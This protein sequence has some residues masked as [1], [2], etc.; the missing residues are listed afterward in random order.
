MHDDDVPVGRLFTRR[1]VLTL[2][3][4]TAGSLAAGMPFDPLARSQAEGLPRCIVRPEQTEG[5]FFIDERLSR[6]DIRT[7]PSTGALSAGAR[8]DLAFDVTRLSGATCRAVPGARVDVWHCDARGAYSD[9]ADSEFDTAGQKF[10]RGHQLTNAEGRARF[11]TIY[12]GWYRGRAVHIH[13]KVRT[14]PDAARGH[15][16]TSQVYFDDAVTDRVHKLAPYAA[17]GV[18]ELRNSRDG[19]FRQG[20]SQL[21]IAPTRSRAGYEATFALALDLG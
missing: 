11:T 13:F 20:G 1:E 19:L 3:G 8:L 17:R 12:P 7:D 15:E 2:L 5:P 4:V 16:F 10:L 6:S 9:V 21:L 14:E 18:R